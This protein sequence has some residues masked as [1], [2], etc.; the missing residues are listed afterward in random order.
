M[1][2]RRLCERPVSASLRDAIS[3]SDGLASQ[4]RSLFAPLPLLGDSSLKT[5][6]V[7][8]LPGQE[9]I[10]RY[11]KVMSGLL[12]DKTHHLHEDSVEIRIALVIEENVIGYLR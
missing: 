2:P 5:A 12:V 9:I 6:Q 4:G 8:K 10:R 7:R 1:R 3:I 11:R